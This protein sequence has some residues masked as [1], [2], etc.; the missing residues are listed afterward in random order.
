MCQNPSAAGNDRAH[1]GSLNRVTMPGCSGRS[2]ASTS[3]HA[4]EL[5]RRLRTISFGPVGTNNDE[6]RADFGDVLD[7]L[8]IADQA[9]DFAEQA[10][11]VERELLWAHEQ[12]LRVPPYALKAFEESVELARARRVA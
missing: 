7:A 11:R 10:L 9:E 4:A 8:G 3:G 5:W 12:G 2:S 6:Q 1:D